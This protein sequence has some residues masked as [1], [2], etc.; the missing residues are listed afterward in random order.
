[1]L[2]R[3]DRHYRDSEPVSVALL[4]DAKASRGRRVLAKNAK[5]GAADHQRPGNAGDASGQQPAVMD[6]FDIERMIEFG[7]RSFRQLWRTPSPRRLAAWRDTV[8][9]RDR[10]NPRSPRRLVQV[11]DPGILT[12]IDIPSIS[13]LTPCANVLSSALFRSLA[14]ERLQ[15]CRKMPSQP[16]LVNPDDQSSASPNRPTL[17][18]GALR[19]SGFP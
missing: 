10:S 1:M 15:D 2:R 4:T 8:C 13:G 17:I 19:R 16:A 5:H 6:R 12:R 3:R 18:S 7:S 9:Q 11:Q 14:P